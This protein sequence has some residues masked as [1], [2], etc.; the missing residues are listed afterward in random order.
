MATKKSLIRG[1]GDPSLDYLK[2]RYDLVSIRVA[3]GFGVRFSDRAKAAGKS[4]AALLQAWI[5][6]DEAAAKKKR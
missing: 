1:G 6:A 3:K 2:E 5:E 4:K